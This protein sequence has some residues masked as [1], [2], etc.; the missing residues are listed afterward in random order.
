MSLTVIDHC[1]HKQV[2]QNRSSGLLRTRLPSAALMNWRSSF[3]VYALSRPQL[4]ERQFWSDGRVHIVVQ[5]WHDP[6]FL[7]MRDLGMLDSYF[8]IIINQR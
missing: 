5:C 4:Y 8:G 6:V 1:R 2:W 3:R 7:N